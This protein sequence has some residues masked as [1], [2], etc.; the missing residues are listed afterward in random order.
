MFVPY[1]HFLAV[2]SD[3]WWYNGSRGDR[4]ITSSGLLVVMTRVSTEEASYHYPASNTRL[5]ATPVPLGQQNGS[6]RS[7]VGS[8]T[9]E[10]EHQ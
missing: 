3:E 10:A 4:L 5:E 2:W 7:A 1:K 9:S 6:L 8:Q